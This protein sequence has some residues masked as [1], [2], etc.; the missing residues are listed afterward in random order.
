MASIHLQLPDDQDTKT[1]ELAMKLNLNRSAYIRR[2]VAEFNARVERELLTEQFQKPRR[3]RLLL[4]PLTLLPHA[5]L[6]HKL[7]VAL[8][9]LRAGA[10]G[11]CT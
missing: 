2:A 11:R 7:L 5:L 6:V 1:R 4:G 3:L 9:K 8:C 10:E